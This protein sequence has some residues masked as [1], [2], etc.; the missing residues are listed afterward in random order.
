MT[1][2]V[3]P[4]ANGRDRAAFAASEVL[5]VVLES[6]AGAPSHQPVTVGL[7]LRR[8]ALLDPGKVELRDGGGRAVACQSH[9][10][11]RWPDGSVRWLLL[12]FLAAV[13]GPAREEWPLH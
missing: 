5:P 1:S 8:G 9:A 4:A 6:T 10:P 13:P 3:E 11:V 2:K 7:P 12:D